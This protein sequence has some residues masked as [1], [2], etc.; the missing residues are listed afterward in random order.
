MNLTDEALSLAAAQV[1]DAM[2]ASLP[3]PSA[4]EHTFSRAFERKMRPLLRRQRHPLFAQAV[5]RAAAFFLT[6][7]VGAGVWLTVD[8]Q[9]REIFFAWVREFYEASVVNEKYFNG[10]L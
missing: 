8:V 7:L 10:R 4:C 9:A 1:R 5:R 6:V 2:P 3:S